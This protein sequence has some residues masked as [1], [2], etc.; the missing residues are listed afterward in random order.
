M[1][2]GTTAFLTTTICAAVAITSCLAIAATASTVALVAYGILAVTSG[3]AGIAS[4]TAYAASGDSDTHIEY[5]KKFKNH[6]GVAIG[7]MYQLVVQ[8]LIFSVIEAIGNAI[9]NIV[10][11][12]ITGNNRQCGVI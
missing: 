9:G 11:K 4:L 7:G 6:S 12:K 8:V 3:G 1:R 10:Y 5:L 2:V